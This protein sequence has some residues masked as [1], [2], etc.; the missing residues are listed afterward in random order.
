[1]TD[2]SIPPL[3]THDEPGVGF[4]V[5]TAARRIAEP[6]E[7]EF[8]VATQLRGFVQ[9]QLVHVRGVKGSGRTAHNLFAWSDL[10]AAAVL[11]TLTHLGI[12]DNEVLQASSLACYA[13][14]LEDQTPVPGAG[15]PIRAALHGHAKGEWWQFRLDVLVNAQTGKRTIKAR[16]CNAEDSSVFPM[17]ESPEDV[18][19]ASVL[20]PVSRFADRILQ[21]FTVG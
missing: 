10:A 3:F 12:A 15:H 11:R 4:T 16:V 18:P 17:P 14:N 13:W 5:G 6:G 2:E 20:L 8:P 7:E 19:M 21:G 9:R 1:M